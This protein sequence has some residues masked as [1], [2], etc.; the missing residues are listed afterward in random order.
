MNF[1]EKITDL[2]DEYDS[3]HE[4]DDYKKNSLKAFVADVILIW[5]EK[6]R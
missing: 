1:K 6:R 3:L 2:I 5:E 4:F